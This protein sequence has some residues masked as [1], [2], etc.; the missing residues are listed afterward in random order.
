[1]AKK[2]LAEIAD[3]NAAASELESVTES[4][5]PATEFEGTPE[6]APETDPSAP[7]SEAP[8]EMQPGHEIIDGVLYINEPCPKCNGTGV[9]DEPCTKCGSHH[10]RACEDCDG[11]GKTRAGQSSLAMIA[12]L[13]K[14]PDA[15]TK[16]LSVLQG[17]SELGTHRVLDILKKHGIVEETSPVTAK[18][19]DKT[20]RVIAEG[21]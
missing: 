1:M 13:Q 18:N 14:T 17:L 2:S 16:R 12:R 10:R 4:N 6:D 7:E 3:D 19:A 9:R 20:W 11:T 8:A 15:N 21:V 5:A